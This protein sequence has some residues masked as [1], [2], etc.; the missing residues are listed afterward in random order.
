MRP[1]YAAPTPLSRVPGPF[2]HLVVFPLVYMRIH[3]HKHA[4]ARTPAHTQSHT[5][6]HTHTHKSHERE[7][8]KERERP[9]TRR[10]S[11]DMYN[12]DVG[13]ESALNL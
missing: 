4:H 10:S 3:T 13:K 11:I 9:Y 5:H 6:T 7:R 12:N 1:G 2:S 8:E